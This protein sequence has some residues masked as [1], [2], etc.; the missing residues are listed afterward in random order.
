MTSTRSL[1]S[2]VSRRMTLVAAVED[3]E[4]GAGWGAGVAVA[5]VAAQRFQLVLGEAW[6]PWAAGAAVALA[7]PLVGALARRRDERAV[8]S[9]ADEKLGLRERLST[10]LWVQRS[11]PE[12]AAEF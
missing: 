11:R 1:I 9:V 7:F 6:L 10:A 5:L 4:R 12:E 3:L 2:R 8:A